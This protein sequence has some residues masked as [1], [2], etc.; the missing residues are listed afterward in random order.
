MTFF[1]VKVRL[2]TGFENK[3][4][5]TCLLI[6]TLYKKISIIMYVFENMGENPQ[7]G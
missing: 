7:E 6:Y 3:F 2:N 1:F 5:I 4:R